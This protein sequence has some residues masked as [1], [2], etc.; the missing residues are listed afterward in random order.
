MASFALV[1]VA[2]PLYAAV[3]SEEPVA[4]TWTWPG[5]GP[6]GTNTQLRTNIFPVHEQAIE[7]LFDLSTIQSGSTV[8]SA[9]LNI[10]RYGGDDTLECEVFRITED[11]DELTLIDSIAHD[12]GH[13][14]GQF[15]ITGNGWCTCD[16]THLVQEWLDATYANYGVVFYGTGGPGSYQYFRSREYST[17]GI[18][19]YLEIDYTPPT[20]LERTT[21]GAIKAAFGDCWRREILS[22]QCIME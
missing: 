5:S 11:W 21:F 3:Y 9:I 1:L 15:V 20:A 6:W 13:P 18:R 19:P 2:G 16:I 22:T 14:Y 10:C 17:S 12:D 8:N 7:L 4:D